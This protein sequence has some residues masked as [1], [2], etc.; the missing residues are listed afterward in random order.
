MR[1]P[2]DQGD[3]AI[4]I[5]V[6]VIAITLA[7]AA[8]H[9]AA[10]I[11]APIVLGLI[12]GVILAPVTERLQKLGLP[13]GLAALTVLVSG[14]VVIAVL[15]FLAEPVIWRIVDQLPRIRWELKSLLSDLRNL[16]RGL[17][18]VNKEVGEALGAKSGASDGEGETPLPTLVDA[19]FVAPIVIAQVLVFS[20]T[21]FFFLLTRANIYAWMSRWI[22]T[23][24]DTDRLRERFATAEKLVSRYFFTITII[25]AGLGA[26]LTAVLLVIGL[27][28]PF[29]WGLIA[30][31]LNFILYLGPMTVTIGLLIAGIVTYDGFVV[32]LPP[33]LFLLLNL[34]EAQFVTPALVGKN[35][36]VNPLLIF[37]SLVIW[38]WLWGPIGAIIAIPVLVITLVMMDVFDDDGKPRHC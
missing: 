20:G 25:N 28:G 14:I 5:A 29:V 27:P 15:L 21:L 33:A 35:I 37:V 24:A 16:V 4:R 38:L 13:A 23:S 31:L 18:E 34:I 6:F 30:A 26:A 9:A 32:L 7:F 11:F 1:T 36:A 8:L 2:S 22:G 19:L 17:D 10:E 3:P 12:L